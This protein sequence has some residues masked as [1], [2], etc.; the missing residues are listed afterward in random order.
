MLRNNQL[1]C[2]NCQHYRAE[3]WGDNFNEP[4]V[5]EESCALLKWE[6][7]EPVPSPVTTCIDFEFAVAE[8]E[9]PIDLNFEEF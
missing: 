1:S 5:T 6:H 2:G 3:T 4:R 7:E 8:I 9:D